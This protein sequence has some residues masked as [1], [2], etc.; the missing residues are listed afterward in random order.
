MLKPNKINAFGQIQ[1]PAFF[2]RKGFCFDFLNRGQ[3][4][5]RARNEAVLEKK[6]NWP[7]GRFFAIIWPL[8]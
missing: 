5:K 7:M 1:L 8:S 2:L 6:L 4:G 3:F